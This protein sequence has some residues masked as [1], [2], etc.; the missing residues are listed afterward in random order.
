MYCEVFEKDGRSLGVGAIEFKTVA[1]AER[2]VTL[3]HQQEM[4]VRKLTVRIDTD[5]NKT[6]QAKE[7][8]L[9]NSGRGSGGGGGDSSRR[10]DRGGNR[11]SEDRRDRGDSSSSG[12]AALALALSQVVAINTQSQDLT[13]NYYLSKKY[14]LY[15]HC[16]KP[17]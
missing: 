10:R 5:G 4:E 13:N 17:Y 3:M 6:R 8:S 15:S 16:F 14:N 12:S 1:D 9:G 11:D 2:A 7:Q